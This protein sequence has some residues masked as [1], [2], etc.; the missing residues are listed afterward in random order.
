[1]IKAFY[2]NRHLPFHRIVLGVLN[3][4][5]F[6]SLGSFDKIKAEYI[7]QSKDFYNHIEWVD[8]INKNIN[9]K[10]D[11]KKII[12]KVDYLSNKLLKPILKIIE[13]EPLSSVYAKNLDFSIIL[14]AWKDRIK[15]L[16]KI[17]SQLK[18]LDRAN[19]LLIT[20]CGNP[21]HKL[22][23]AAFKE[24]GT[25]VINFT[26]GND[27]CYLDQRWTLNYLISTCNQYAFETEKLATVFKKK[28]KN[29]VL[30]FKDYFV[31]CARSFKE[32]C[33]ECQCK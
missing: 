11:E 15:D 20:E 1:M 7:A 26:H 25:G 30:D 21:F 23:A 27:L 4:N 19:K 13:C 3:K 33:V 24:K 14:H 9:A 6:L 28:S 22:I 16:F 18:Y 5:S 31:S 12:Y 8:L 2:F 29:L 10:V 17:L 32:T